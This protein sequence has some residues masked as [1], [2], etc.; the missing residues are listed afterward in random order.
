M[1]NLT[2]EG[3]DSAKS[4]EANQAP[5][6]GPNVKAIANAIP[7]RAYKITTTGLVTSHV[8]DNWV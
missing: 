8:G 1:P 3:H 5:M 2:K 6:A 4:M 7:T